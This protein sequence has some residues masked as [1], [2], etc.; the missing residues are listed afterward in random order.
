MELVT[1]QNDALRVD[2]SPMGAEIQSII[3]AG[4]VERMWNGD[5]AFWTGRAPV[6]FPIAGSLK[7]DTYYLDGKAYTLPK[8]GFARRRMFA[9]ESQEATRATFL[10]TGEAGYDPGFPFPYA[11]RATYALEG[12]ALVAT[13]ACENLGEAPFYFSV[14]AHEAYA[15][16]E[17]IDAY[18][19]VF[20]ET[21]PLMREV[22]DGGLTGEQELV[23]TQ[24]NVLPL[25]IGLFAND[26][27]V[28]AG[29]EQHSVLLRSRLHSRE[30]R[31]DFE[32]FPYLLI[33]TMP[34]AGYICI[35]PW[36]N[37]PDRF[38][39]DQDIARKPG[40]M[41]LDAGES[42]AI[43]HTITFA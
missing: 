32:D 7:D 17:G 35:E 36:C 15:C 27:L 9:V 34:G 26:T 12:N 19:I 3:D 25:H 37:L 24:D 41:R 33:W 23:P 40:M 29:L 22:L 43:A 11:L 10:L 1:L 16:P 31:V 18:E 30:I 42:R 38:D 6:L 8:H 5:P 28:F 20:G 4:G 13:Y 21:K 2:I 14:G 39:T